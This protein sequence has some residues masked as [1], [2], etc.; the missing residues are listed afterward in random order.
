MSGQVGTHSELLIITGK[1]SL[2]YRIIVDITLLP[3][4]DEGFVTKYPNGFHTHQD[5]D[6]LEQAIEYHKILNRKLNLP[7]PVGTDNEISN[8]SDITSENG[9]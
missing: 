2:T 5:F 8:L 4:T 1:Q 9:R 3:S 6:N 7:D